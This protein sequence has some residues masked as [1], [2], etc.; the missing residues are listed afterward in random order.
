[1][2][3]SKN[4]LIYDH[5]VTS[6]SGSSVIDTYK[7][8]YFCI[9]RLLQRCFRT[10]RLWNVS[11][12]SKTYNRKTKRV[13]QTGKEWTIHTNPRIYLTSRTLHFSSRF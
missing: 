13:Y 4:V 2:L 6:V 3:D 12:R 5:Y 7:T 9:D 8:G 11:H 1:M 10:N